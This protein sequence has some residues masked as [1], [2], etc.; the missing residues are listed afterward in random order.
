MKNFDIKQRKCDFCEETRECFGVSNHQLCCEC[1]D[2][3][4]PL[5]S[6]VGSTIF[7]TVPEDECDFVVK[8]RPRIVDFYVRNKAKS[9]RLGVT[10]VPTNALW[11]IFGFVKMEVES[12]EVAVK[13]CVVA[14]ADMRSLLLQSFG[15]SI[16]ATPESVLEMADREGEFWRIFVQCFVYQGLLKMEIEP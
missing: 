9:L 15:T 4:R 10:Y 8:I 12:F 7:L 11:P 5:M 16:A 13:R 2:K 6:A 1:R 14:T 3:I